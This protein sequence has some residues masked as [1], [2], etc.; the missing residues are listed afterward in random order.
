MLFARW[1]AK[2]RLMG[3]KSQLGESK[4]EDMEECEKL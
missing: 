4:R 1:E 3:K 2:Y